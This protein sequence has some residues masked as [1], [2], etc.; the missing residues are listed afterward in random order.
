VSGTL[1]SLLTLTVGC[2][3]AATIF[4]FGAEVFSW[5]SAYAGEAGRVTL[6]QTS[7]LA[8]L[9]ALAVLLALRG[10]W[11]GIPAAVAMALAA[12]A[13]EWALFPLAYEW[14]ALD[15]PA[16]YARRFGEVRRPGY[17]A[18]STY[19][20]IAAGFA[21]ALTQ[22]LRTVAGVSPTGPRDG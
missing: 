3:V 10:G 11:W 8:V 22:G 2:A 19:D 15:D 4:G 12:T 18:W 5:R 20:V 7:R 16:G 1:R 21:A 9:V 6:I 14:A 13:V 17:G